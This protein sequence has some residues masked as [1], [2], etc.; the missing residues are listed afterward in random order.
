MNSDY[1]KFEI[2]WMLI[3]GFMYILIMI[4]FPFFY[5]TKYIPSIAGIPLFI[6]GWLVHTTITFVLIVIYAKQA[7][8][9]KEYQE[10]YYF[11]EENKDD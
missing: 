5:S 10:S 7:L 6:I 2:K 4:P 9:R 11:G 8:A 3:F 1:K